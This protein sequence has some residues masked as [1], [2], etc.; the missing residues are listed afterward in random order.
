MRNAIGMA[1][2]MKRVKRHL[3]EQMAMAALA[4]SF[5]SVQWEKRENGGLAGQSSEG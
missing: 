3:V 4:L 2:S 5:F 1:E